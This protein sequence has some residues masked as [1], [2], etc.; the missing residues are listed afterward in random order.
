MQV[1]VD[2]DA[3]TTSVHALGVL[4][5]VAPYP[6]WWI[7]KK[8]LSSSPIPSCGPSRMKRKMNAWWKGTNVNG[9]RAALE[10]RHHVLPHV[11]S[12]P[13]KRRTGA[14]GWPSLLSSMSCL[15]QRLSQNH[16]CP[17][18]LAPS[19]DHNGEGGENVVR[20][21]DLPFLRQDQI[22]LLRQR[23]RELEATLRDQ[24][25]KSR[26]WQKRLDLVLDQVLSN[27]CIEDKVYAY[28]T[29]KGTDHP[30]YPLPPHSHQSTRAHARTRPP[31]PASKTPC[32][33]IKTKTPL[34]KKRPI[35][36]P[37]S[38]FIMPRIQ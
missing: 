12:H 8:G 3:G 16:P 4:N 29:G 37:P 14:R 21:E 31:P 17:C 7:S 32:P 19:G 15:Q 6:L 33:I 2:D 25:Q 35:L 9:E 27:E 26:M 24:Q 28:Y 1:C 36:C 30:L 13:L 11:T 38:L 34:K 22:K 5:R 20:R 23:I 10:I 18:H